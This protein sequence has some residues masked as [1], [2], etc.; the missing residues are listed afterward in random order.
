VYVSQCQGRPVQIAS[1]VVPL[2]T[3]VQAQLP[4]A[5]LIGL[6]CEGTRGGTVSAVIA[7][8]EAFKTLIYVKLH[9]G[10]HVGSNCIT[11]PESKA[12][13]AESVQFVKLEV[14]P[15]KELLPLS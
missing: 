3:G 15:E 5:A 9:R 12:S 4:S 1:A 10:Q 7:I 6:S 11:L 8:L 14:K 13:L 2:S